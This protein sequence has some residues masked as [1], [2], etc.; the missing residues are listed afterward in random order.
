LVASKN[1][2]RFSPR[3]I[4]EQLQDP[5]VKESLAFIGLTESYEI[6][7]YY[8]TD[9]RNLRKHLTGYNVNSDYTPFVEFNTDSDAPMHE[10]LK[11]FVLNTRD[12]SII[13]HMDWS[14]FNE[15]DK[16]QW[17]A[18]YEQLYSA[19]GYLLS[20]YG[21]EKLIDRFSYTVAGL[22]EY[23]GNRALIEYKEELEKGLVSRGIR[24]VVNENYNAALA[25]ANEIQKID[26]SS[27]TIW[28]IRSTVMQATGDFERAIYAAEQA[29]SL[30]P[31]NSEVYFN[32]GFVYWR[33][34]QFGQSVKNLRQ[35]LDIKP[36]QLSILKLISELL[37]R[38]PKS[39]YYSPED[40]LEFISKANELSEGEDVE[41]L[42]ILADAYFVNGETGK[43]IEAIEQAIQVAGKDN[44]D[45]LSMLKSKLERY[46]AK[47][48]KF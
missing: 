12:D 18:N 6:L 19:A 43:A 2:Q 8:V 39:S 9:E 24:L 21:E 34:K 13:D 20:S 40:A 33:A 36:E 47:L 22:S 1:P 48:L 31:N 45:L 35:S 27:A 10:S 29:I 25:M 4:D 23:P 46:K 11:K 30:D 7:N 16:E 14:G 28:M 17:L 42:N 3:H 38:D 26:S 15:S 37:L 44:R 41:V 5:A 32:A